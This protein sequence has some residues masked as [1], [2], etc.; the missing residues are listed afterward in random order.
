VA[1]FVESFHIRSTLY[2]SYRVVSQ[3]LNMKNE[4]MK[5]KTDENVANEWI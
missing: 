2:D 1:F 5:M 3:Q 4:W